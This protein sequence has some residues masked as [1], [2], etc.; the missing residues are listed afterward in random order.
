MSIL[1]RWDL[2]LARVAR[3]FRAASVG[4]STA[5]YSKHAKPDSRS[6]ISRGSR[7]ISLF[8][9]HF[10]PLGTWVWLALL[11][12]ARVFGGTPN[13][14]RRRRMPPVIAFAQKPNR[15]IVVASEGVL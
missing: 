6:R 13:T 11:A 10:V 14:T 5:K 9:E 1:S 12:F 4:K 2:G 7:L 8:D 15:A 3:C